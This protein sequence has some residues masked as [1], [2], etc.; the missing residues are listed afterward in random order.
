[1]YLQ[2]VEGTRDLEVKGS[3]FK[4]IGEVLRDEMDDPQQALDAFMEALLLDPS[5]GK[6]I[7]AVEAIA[8][9]RSWWNELLATLKRE[10]G[11]VKDVERQVLICEHAM[12]WAKD[13][14]LKSPA[15]GRAVPRSHP[16]DRP[17]APRDS[18]PPGRACTESTPRG[19]RRRTRSSEPC[20]GR[21]TSRR[22]SRSTSRSAT[23]KEQRLGDTVG[24]AIH[25]EAALEID[26]YSMPGACRGWNACAA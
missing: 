24:A 23:V 20:C 9:E 12:R 25:Y 3:L 21:A 17:C 15:R 8:R 6:A 22:G 1:M 7:A 11:N 18:P 26:P 5:D 4:R 10:V 13:G 2:R 14:G 19:N 16:A